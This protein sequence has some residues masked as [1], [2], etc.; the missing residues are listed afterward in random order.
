M[1]LGCENPLTHTLDHRPYIRLIV[2]FLLEAILIKVKTIIPLSKK[3]SIVFCAVFKT[4]APPS[5]PLPAKGGRIIRSFAI[6]YT[7]ASRSAQSVIKSQKTVWEKSAS[8]N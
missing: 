4:F 8:K 6:D 7:Y 3:L 1:T 5:N 2:L